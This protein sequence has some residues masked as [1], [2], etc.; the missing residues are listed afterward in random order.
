VWRIV[1]VISLF[2]VLA[3]FGV[4]FWMRSYLHSEE[5]RVFIGDTVGSA[6]GGEAEFERFEWQGMDVR[7]GGMKLRHSGVLQ[8]MEADG[9]QARLGLSGV[10]R[11]VW[12][13]SDLRV[14]RLNVDLSTVTGRG[15]EVPKVPVSPDKDAVV[16]KDHGGEGFLTGW[17]PDRAELMSAEVMHMDLTL[18]TASG[19]LKFKDVAMRVDADRSAGSYDIHLADG[20][21]DSPWFASSLDLM[22][23]RGKY[24][25]GRIFLTKSQSKIY[26]RGILTLRGEVEGGK[27]GFFGTIKD[28]RSEEVLPKDWKKRVLGDIVSQFKVSSGKN[29]V[30]TQ[31]KIELH[32]GVLTALPV[33]DRIAAYANS[34]R[35][36]RL[37][38]SDARLKFWRQG[39]HLKLTDIV[40]SSEGLIRVEG[41]LNVVGGRLDGRFDVGIMP[42][43]LAHIPGAETKVFL[44]GKKGL[45]WSPLHITGTVDA[46]KEDLSERMIAAAGE[47]M[48]ELVPETGMKALKFAHD[49]A[50]QL[51]Q[52]AIKTGV[53][54]LQEGSGVIQEGPKI[55][56]EGVK[57]VFDLLPGK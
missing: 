12:E 54:V 32:Q 41:T 29:G 35:F 17:L 6:V 9:V 47:R 24:Q 33:L 30:V 8:K 50:T 1:A 44:R 57:G 31:G 27:F 52:K 4:Y 28:V 11:G 40:L 14:S 13:I 2:A 45:L 39:D 53:D 25:H 15:E 49:T 34:R 51:P 46:P 42:G 20:V 23:A 3:G 5:F 56:Q 22:S 36:R 37:H 55:I 7:T 10:R 38:L 43:T 16:R 21:V 48:F 19:D 26:Q 18:R